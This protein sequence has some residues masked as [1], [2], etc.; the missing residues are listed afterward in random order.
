MF[1]EGLSTDEIAFK[2]ATRFPN[3]RGPDTS[4][5]GYNPRPG[6][7]PA[8]FD[9]AARKQMQER[10]KAFMEAAAQQ[11]QATP[12]PNQDPSRVPQVTIEDLKNRFTG[13]GRN[14]PPARAATPLFPDISAADR[15]RPGYNPSQRP[16]T[17]PPQMYQ[18]QAPA[19][20]PTPQ[21]PQQ[22]LAPEMSP[23]GGMGN[24]G[25]TQKQPQQASGSWGAGSNLYGNA[26]GG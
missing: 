6:L 24:L 7:D 8:G 1:W 11:P 10:W 25:R 5:P 16:S 19:T 22:M 14:G 26:W 3:R 15:S 17:T 2:G 13:G 12:F 20:K 4:R 9:E 21:Q 18:G 23:Y